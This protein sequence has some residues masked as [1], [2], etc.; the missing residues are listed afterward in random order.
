[1]VR[2]LSVLGMSLALVLAI[3]GFALAQGDLPMVKEMTQGDVR[4]M[5]GGIGLEEREA[6]EA[7]AK[8]YNLKLV[9]A[10]ASRE[11]LSDIQ[12][13][14]QDGVGK[15]LLSTDAKGPWL[16][17]KLPEGDYTVQ[18]A[19]GGQKK[20]QSVKAGRGLLTVNILWK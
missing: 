1:M 13:T 12:V 19:M 18:A 2:V 8:D 17:L 4:Y 7:K 15:T 14:I 11:Y 10:M 6:M 20:V 3:F 5:T 16:Y 9:F